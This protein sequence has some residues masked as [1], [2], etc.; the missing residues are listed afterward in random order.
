[1]RSEGLNRRE[2]IRLAGTGAAICLAGPGLRPLRAAPQGSP[3]ISPG[4]RGSKV[5][6]ARLFMANPGSAWPKP[7]LDLHQE[8]A[9]YR[10]E[11]ARR[12]EDFADIDFCVDELVTKQGQVTALKERLLGADGVLVIQLNIEIGDLLKEILMAGRPTML[13]ARPYSG[14]EWVGYGALRGEPLGA[15]LDCLLTSDTG[16]L[17]L[18]V[19]PFRAIHHLREARIINLS[20]ADFSG[21]AGKM[22]A[23]FGTEIR[24]V[25]LSRL[26][27]FYDDISDKDARAETEAWLREAAQIV[28]PSREDVFK[29]CKLALAFEKLLADEDATVMTVDCYGTMWDRTIKLPAYP[30]LG[31]SRLNNLGLGGICE[32]D[33]R[34]AMVHILFQGLAGRPG[35]VSD[36]T[37]DESRES[38]ILAHCLGTPKMAGPSNPAAP[39]KLRTVMERQEG[40]VPQVEMRTGERVTQAILV[41]TDTLRYFTGTIIAAPVGLEA[42]RGCRTKIEVKVDG[43]VTRLWRNWTAGLHRQTVYGDIRKEL[44]L[45][46]RFAGVRIEDEAA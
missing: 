18:A 37:V 26:V 35:F 12:K 23:K 32:S 41:G 9:F 14:H 24:P 43:G 6:V 15:K 1:M 22:K 28:E 2:F 27:D 38:I 13:F 42:D 17:S 44:E 21:Y 33:L 30:C 46:A 29:S 39:F 36:P 45:W 25:S 31:F 20:T 16:A 8:I 19:R 5:K 7:S 40:V 10:G 4:C 34:C 11:F 3:L